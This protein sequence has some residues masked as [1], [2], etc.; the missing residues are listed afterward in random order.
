MKKKLIAL[1]VALAIPTSAFA[2]EHG[3]IT[4][5]RD[6]ITPMVVEDA[7]GGTWDHDF[8]VDQPY[9]HWSNY[10]HTS[11]THKSSAG[12]LFTTVSSEWKS[13]TEGWTYATCSDTLFGNTANWDTK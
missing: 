6:G 7:G 3:S 11:K 1:V 13:S 12:N 5:I 4:M 8:S 2:A 10:N 9:R